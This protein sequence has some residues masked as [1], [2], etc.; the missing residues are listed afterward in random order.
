MLLLYEGQRRR[1]T[2]PHHNKLLSADL[3]RLTCP[4]CLA[5]LR[6]LVGLLFE[7]ENFAKTEEVCRE[8]LAMLPSVLSRN[9]VSSSPT[10]RTVEHTLF[11]MHQFISLSL[12]GRGKHAEAL[13][14]AS[15]AEVMLKSSKLE[16]SP[17][18]LSIREKLAQICGQS[19]HS[20][21]FSLLL[22]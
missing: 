9:G 20:F 16:G 15:Q 19:H 2:S 12:I 1:S 10:L 22:F 7:A 4:Q 5:G 3:F 6:L 18:F 21:S 14:V 8:V 11:E 17:P 13:K